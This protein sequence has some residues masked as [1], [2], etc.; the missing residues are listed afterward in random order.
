MHLLSYQNASAQTHCWTVVDFGIL[1]VSLGIWS[2]RGKRVSKLSHRQDVCR[3]RKTPKSYCRDKWLAS[4]RRKT[5][6]FQVAV[7]FGGS[8]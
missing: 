5:T 3:K 1:P 7:I 6:M 4:L 8:P 2:T